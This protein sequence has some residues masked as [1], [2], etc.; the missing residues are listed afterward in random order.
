M[1]KDLEKYNTLIVVFSSFMVA[2]SFLYSSVEIFDFKLIGIILFFSGVS[3]IIYP[4]FGG[5][6]DYTLQRMLKPL[7]EKGKVKSFR[8]V[9]M[10]V[11]YI[12]FKF[13]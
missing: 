9:F 3:G 8:F 11:F 12:F 5:L 2:G 6:S 1:L 7:I 4:V 10:S 13:F